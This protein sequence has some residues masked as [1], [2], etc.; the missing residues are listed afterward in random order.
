LYRS[1]LASL[2]G[3]TEA[4]ASTRNPPEWLSIVRNIRVKELRK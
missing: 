3:E 4:A 2:T 1:L